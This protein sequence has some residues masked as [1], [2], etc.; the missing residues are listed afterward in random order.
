MGI[1]NK[2]GQIITRFY[3]PEVGAEAWEGNILGKDGLDDGDAAT[4]NVN[5]GT[6]A[7]ST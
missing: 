7:G 4:I 1:I 2:T 3:V 5:D 6:G